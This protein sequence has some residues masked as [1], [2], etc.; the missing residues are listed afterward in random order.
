MLAAM[1]HFLHSLQARFP[2]PNPFPPR[3]RSKWSRPHQGKREM[4]RRVRQMANGT[5]GY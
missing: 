2:A 1:P 5:H 4:A 3:Q